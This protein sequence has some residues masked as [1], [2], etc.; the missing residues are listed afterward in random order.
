M[1]SFERP[2]T[3]ARTYARVAGP[4]LLIAEGRVA[5]TSRRTFGQETRR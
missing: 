2:N 4:L 1:D 3:Q 5:T